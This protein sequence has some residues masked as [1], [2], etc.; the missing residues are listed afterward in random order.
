MDASATFMLVI[1]VSQGC[2]VLVDISISYLAKFLARFLQDPARILLNLREK[3][4]FLQFLQGLTRHSFKMV[5]IGK[6]L[7]L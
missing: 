6:L 7:I 1:C 4:L 5:S 3:D 2:L